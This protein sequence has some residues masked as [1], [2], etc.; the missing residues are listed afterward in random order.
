MSPNGIT[1][2]ISKGGK[3]YWKRPVRRLKSWTG[4]F[5]RLDRPGRTAYS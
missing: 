4:G 2:V 5:L 3:K 1:T